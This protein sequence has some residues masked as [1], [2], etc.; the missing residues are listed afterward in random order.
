MP[1]LILASTSRYR[2]ELLRRLGIPFSVEAPNVDETALAGETPGD[3]AIRLAARKALAIA[4]LHRNAIVIGS[5]QLAEHAGT[6]LGKPGT[7]ERAI[8]QLERMSGAIVTFHTAVAVACDSRV[9]VLSVPTE[10]KFRT[11]SRAE[12]ERYIDRE[13]PLDCAGSFKSEAL[14]VVLFERMRSDD[15]TALIGLPLIETARMLRGFGIDPL[16]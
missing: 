15:P 4:A 6:S 7:V 14:G 9:D 5:D 11:L 13:Q 12:I 8:A 2:A 3:T 16:A 1:E 10:V